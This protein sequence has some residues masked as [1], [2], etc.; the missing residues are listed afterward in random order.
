MFCTELAYLKL[1]SDK[2]TQESLAFVMRNYTCCEDKT[3]CCLR[4]TCCRKVLSKRLQVS[5]RAINNV[6]NLILLIKAED[7]VFTFVKVFHTK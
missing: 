3:E 7:L 5:R 1:Y 4:E 6:K 2:N